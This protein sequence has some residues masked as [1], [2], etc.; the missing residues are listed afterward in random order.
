MVNT[1]NNTVK[2]HRTTPLTT[3]ST[4]RLTT[5]RTTPLTTHSTTRLTKQ[6]KTHRTTQLPTNKFNVS[7]I[8]SV[9]WIF[10]AIRE[11]CC[12]VSGHYFV[13]WFTFVDMKK[14]RNP[15][16][17]LWGFR[18]SR[19]PDFERIGTWKWW[20]CQQYAATAFTP[21]EIHVYLVLICVRDCFH[22]AAKIMSMKNPSDT[23]GNRTSD[24]PPRS[25]VPQPNVLPRALFVYF[26]FLPP[27][28]HIWKCVFELHKQTFGSVPVKINQSH[29]RPGQAQRVPGS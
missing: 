25:A 1:E 6:L 4:T 18:S 29:Y 23:I 11:L 19:L 14:W 26:R 24:L 9:I 20:G 28:R 27:L 22:A 2:T 10:K 13:Y 15:C 17:R 16:N 8:P 3:H 7:V 5:C 12:R 21:P